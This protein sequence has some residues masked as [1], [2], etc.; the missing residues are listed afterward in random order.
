MNNIEKL[1]ADVDIKKNEEDF[2]KAFQENDNDKMWECV[3]HACRNICKNIYR[4]RGFIAPEDL[5]D[6]VT[7]EATLMIMNNIKNKNIRPEKLSSY[8]YLRCF[9]CVNQYNQKE[10]LFKEKL[11]E[12]NNGPYFLIYNEEDD[13]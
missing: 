7:M 11:K 6:D 4:N 5:L 3:Y 10:D 9:A 13:K 2:Q 12:L 1:K 8:C